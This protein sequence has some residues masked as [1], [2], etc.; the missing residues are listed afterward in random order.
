MVA[1]QNTFIGH[2]ASKV[3]LPLT[4]LQSPLSY[5]ELNIEKM[6]PNSTLL[7]FSS[8]PFPFHKKIDELKGLG[9]PAAVVNGQKFS[10]FG[11]SALEFLETGK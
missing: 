1:T 8:E 2:V 7:L 5:P 11:I 4:P 10:W 9:I 6:N 3:G